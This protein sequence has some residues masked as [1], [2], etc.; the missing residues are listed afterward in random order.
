M[1]DGQFQIGGNLGLGPTRVRS[2]E[3]LALSKLRHP[4]SA[5][6]LEALL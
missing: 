6:G 4:A 1:L 2:I 5:Y 3:K